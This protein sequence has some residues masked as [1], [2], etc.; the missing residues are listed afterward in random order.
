MTTVRLSLVI[1]QGSLEGG[2]I[3]SWVKKG[4]VPLL[5]KKKAT[6]WKYVEIPDVSHYYVPY[7]ALYE[8]LRASF[9]DFAVSQDELAEGL[10]SMNETLG[11]LAE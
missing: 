1:T 6:G 3:R 8:G 9:P 11:E 2:D 4:I 5:K 10:N 7:K